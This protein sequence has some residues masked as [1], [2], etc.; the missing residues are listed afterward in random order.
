M[1]LLRLTRA[2]I[3]YRQPLLAP[4]DLSVRQGHRLAVL[5]P[6]GGGK[7]TLLKSL[8]GLLPLLRGERVTRVGKRLSI[9]YVPQAHRADPVYP[10]TSLQVTLQGRYGLVGVGRFVTRKDRQAARDHLGNVGLAEQADVPFRS[11]SGGQRQRVLL[12]RALCA[13]PELLVLDEFTSDLDPAASSALLDEVSQLASTS[14]VSVVFVT[15]EIAAA[16]THSAE[17][18]LVDTRRG[19]FETGPTASLLTS[20]GMTRLYGQPISVETKG[21][22]TVVH[23]EAAHRLGA[24]GGVL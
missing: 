12:A 11:L 22:R 17:V 16:A 20:E 2:E 10:L 13:D 6:N 4:F 15:H 8:I 3:G 14:G 18:A 5:G 19:V 7:S 24:P 9:G 23:V 1:E 21:D